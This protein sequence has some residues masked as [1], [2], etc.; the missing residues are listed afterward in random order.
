LK[1]T[2][3]RIMA[4][5][6]DNDK[7][8]SYLLGQLSI[9]VLE[10]CG[11]HKDFKDKVCLIVIDDLVN[12]QEKLKKI[13]GEILKFNS[14]SYKSN[15]ESVEQMI[16]KSNYFSDVDLDIMVEI[17]NLVRLALEPLKPY[18]KLMSEIGEII[19]NGKLDDDR[20]ID[21]ISNLLL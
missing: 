12:N 5:S 19:K 11:T 8:I 1:I 21:S 16:K 4:T 20:K 17:M 18:N 7:K 10:E 6:K 9:R 13:R 3:H 15:E 2:H 14:R